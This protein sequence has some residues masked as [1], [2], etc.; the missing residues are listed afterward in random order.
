LSEEVSSSD[1][2]DPSYEAK[3]AFFRNAFRLLDFNEIPGD[4]CEFGCNT[5]VTFRLAHEGLTQR[6]NPLA[7]HMWAFDSFAGLPAQRGEFDAHPVWVEGTLVT[8]LE[9]F[10]RLCGEYGIPPGAY[11]AVP[12]FYADSLATASEPAEVALAHVDCD[13]YTSAVEVMDWLAPRMRNGMIVA[14][15]D[16]FC[17]SADQLAGERRALIEF[18]REHE[19]WRWVPYSQYWW[20]AQSFLIEDRELDP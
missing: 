9:D 17:A 7:R 6:E 18:Q 15:D 16:Y 13:L 19:R 5:A 2:A 20:A 4:F 14:F 12:G 3:R 10:R 8:S 11:T 1:L